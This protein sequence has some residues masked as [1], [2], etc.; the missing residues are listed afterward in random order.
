MFILRIYTQQSVPLKANESIA[1][2]IISVNKLYHRN[3]DH[4]LAFWKCTDRTGTHALTI[5]ATI[6]NFKGNFHAIKLHFRKQICCSK[7]FVC[8]FFSE[9]N[10]F[11]WEEQKNVMKYVI[12]IHTK[13]KHRRRKKNNYQLLGIIVDQWKQPK[14]MPLLILAFWLSRIFND[15][16]FRCLFN[17]KKMMWFIV[18]RLLLLGVLSHLMRRSPHI[19]AP[20]NDEQND[21]HEHDVIV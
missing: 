21:G 17:K 5:V 9:W 10:H 15:L 4:W 18:L 16:S 7:L 20:K 1:L 6:S 14:W 12:E 11:R 13:Y 8:S 19:L 2:P 3:D